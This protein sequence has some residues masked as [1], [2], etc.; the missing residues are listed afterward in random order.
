MTYAWYRGNTAITDA[1]AATYVAQAGDT[2]INCRVTASGVTSQSPSI[3][4]RTEATGGTPINFI[5]PTISG[6]RRLGKTLTCRRGSWNDT[7]AA[8][9]PVTYRW[10]RGGVT[11][12]TQATYTITA[13]DINV[14]LNCEVTANTQTVAA[15]GSVTGS[16][17]EVIITPTISGD[18]RLRQVMSCSRGAWHEDAA[19][20]YT[21]TYRWLRNGTAIPGATAATYTITTADLDTNLYCEARAE[22]L[23]ASQ[24]P[25]VTVTAPRMVLSQVLSGQPR[26]RKTMSC[27]RGTWDDLASDRY[28]VT[29]QWFRDSVAIPDATQTTYAVLA[30]DTGKSL[31]CQTRA[32]TRTPTN[33]VNGAETVRAPLNRIV[34]RLSGMPRVRQQLSCGRG[35]WDDEETDRYSVTYR[36]FRGSTAIPNQTTP[37]YTITAAD[38]Q[39]S[40]HCRVRAED[41]TEA[42][43][44][45]IS[46]RRPDNVVAP[47][48][49][50]DPRLF[51]T[52]SCTRGDWDDTAADRYA[53]TYSWLRNSVAIP[54]AT[55]ANYTVGH[56]DMNKSLSCRVRAEDNL[57]ANSGAVG[58]DLPR[59]IVPPQISGQPH[60][61]GE[62]TCT[63]G[64]WD[65]TPERRYAISYQWYRSGT[66]ISGATDPAYVLGT[67]DLNRYITCRAT[68]EVLRDSAADSLYV[69]GPY[70]TVEPTIEGIA[71]PRREL[72]CTRGEWNDSPAN[73]YVLT[74]QW[75]R[76]NTPIAG[77][78][79]P[80]HIVVAE[81]V[82]GY[83]RCAVTAEGQHTAWSWYVYPGWEPLRVG[84][85]ADNDA[86]APF[87]ANAYTLRVRNDNPVAVTITNLELTMPGGFSYRSGTTTGALT[88]DPALTGPGSLTLLWTTDFQVPASGESV[89]RV[90]VTAGSSTGDFFASATGRPG[91]RRLQQPADGPH[92]AHHRRGRRPRAARARSTA[93][94]ATTCCSAPTATM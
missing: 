61:R 86:T 31:S 16:P 9:Y 5:A 45:S 15:S 84:L 23:T 91:Q 60:L 21:I 50:G 36:W 69:Y 28:A 76:N 70:D 25:A 49:T 74:Y 77:A 65:D 72:S 6:D 89:V 35:D 56:D 88:T 71:Y 4:L 24:S 46:I 78:D 81:D 52:L 32:E 63:R 30:T 66:P 3:G 40:L 33:P 82:G 68:A 58:P 79:G 39:Q 22:S 55:S 83:L 20:P 10:R 59:A 51:R 19:T 37:T 2:S 27:G 62:L 54:G 7:A 94:P 1:T 34:P 85:T 67:A 12:G 75:Y 47:Q 17:P 92:R 90:G 73:P 44:A 8:P 41:Q 87:A 43:S 93:R 26:L 57:D 11:I 53:V 42:Q 14:S 13:D 80:D 38:I 48:I 29:H 64:T 18:P